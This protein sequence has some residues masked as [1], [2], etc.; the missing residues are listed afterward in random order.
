[1]QQCT[2]VL[3]DG[4]VARERS[5][6]LKPSCMPRRPRVG[7]IYFIVNDLA[8]MSICYREKTDQ[9]PVVVLATLS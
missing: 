2:A 5:F 1:M 9:S 3:F 6:F 8:C 7:L 4:R